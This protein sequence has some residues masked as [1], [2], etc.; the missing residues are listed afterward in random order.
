MSDEDVDAHSGLDSENV[1]RGARQLR[2]LANVPSKVEQIDRIEFR[3]KAG[4]HTVKRVVVDEAA[5]R[6]QAHNPLVF[7]PVA[8]PSDRLDVGVALFPQQRRA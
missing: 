1:V 8:E 3:F 6:H 5:V 7:D 2:I 4:S